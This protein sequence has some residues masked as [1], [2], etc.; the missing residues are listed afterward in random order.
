MAMKI[1][2]VGLG[3]IAKRHI[4]NLTSILKDRAIEFEIDIFRHTNRP[5][6]D[7]DII[8][9]IHSVYTESDLSNNDCVYDI[10]FITNPTSLHYETIKKWMKCMK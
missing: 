10:A 9:K 3:S 7:A 5:I 8:T 1:A 4:L 6:E 2:F